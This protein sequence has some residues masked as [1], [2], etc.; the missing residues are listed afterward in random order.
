MNKIRE[1]A[2]LLLTRRDHSRREL[3]Q[4][5]Q[6]KGFPP[7][8]ISPTLDRLQQDNLLNE[9]R[10][11]TSFI[12]SR[13]AKGFGPLKICAELQKH[14]IDSGCILANEE[15]Q[16]TLWF[17]AAIKVR[18]KR[19][20]ADIPPEKQERLRQARYL[21]QRGFTADHIRQALSSKK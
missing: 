17:E 14:G 6:L 12:R 2:L 5:L 21:Q 8:E 11:I 20:G 16:E 19:F 4:K 9:E 18:T 15:W 3:H 7:A 10:F 1:R 13:R